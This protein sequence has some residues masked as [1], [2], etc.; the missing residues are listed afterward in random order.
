MNIH[1]D[2]IKEISNQHPVACLLW[3]PDSTVVVIG[4]AQV[5]EREVDVAQCRLSGVP[6]IRRC[7]GGGA[8]VL[9]PGVLCITLAFN[10]R[11]SASPSFFFHRINDFIS[12]RLAA[13]FNIRGIHRAGSSDLAIGDKKILGCS[14]YKSRQNWLYQGSLLVNPDLHLIELFLRHPSKEP[15]YRQS[16]S[17]HEFITG[18]QS[19]GYSLTIAELEQRLGID[20]Q[21]KLAALIA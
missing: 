7:G 9:M 21:E 19:C 1:D 17:H 18:L 5:A 2:L 12:E 4:Y 20:C 10:S 14:I 16:R 3:Q 11:Q 8:V 6:I 15:D 13:A